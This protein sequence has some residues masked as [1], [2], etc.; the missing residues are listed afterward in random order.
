MNPS[1]P[2]ASRRIKAFILSLISYTVA[3]SYRVQQLST[4]ADQKGCVD[5]HTLQYSWILLTGVVAG[6][7]VGPWLLSFAHRAM[8]ALMPSASELSRA[9]RIKAVAGS[10]ILLGMALNFLW[11]IPRLN[12]FIDTHP[13]LLV[14]RP[15]CSSISVPIIPNQRSQA[16]PKNDA[17]R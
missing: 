10:F 17:E 2:K 4:R 15:Q 8:K 11:I 13:V 1:S 14:L 6:I 3:V 12:V 9:R 16:N 7:A 5:P